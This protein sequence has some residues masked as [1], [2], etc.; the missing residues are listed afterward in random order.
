M[1]GSVRWRPC[2][3][4]TWNVFSVWLV[5]ATMSDMAS[6]IDRSPRVTSAMGIG[7]LINR[8]ALSGR[9]PSPKLL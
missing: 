9:P 2:S 3:A 8:I 4:P 6:G 5:W 7:P 1:L